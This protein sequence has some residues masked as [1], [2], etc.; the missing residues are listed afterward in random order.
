MASLPGSPATVALT[1][2]VINPKARLNYSSLSFGNVK[3]GKSST[4]SVV[5]T[6]VG[7]TPLEINSITV[8][9]SSTL[10]NSTC[11]SL[12]PKATCTINVTFKPTSKKSF[13]G[14]LEIS[15]NASSSPQTVSLSGKGN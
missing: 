12:A 7:D 8:S 15:D 14:T 3:V 13:A 9:G 11:T 2:T 1:G 5:P 6:S 4:L 10:T